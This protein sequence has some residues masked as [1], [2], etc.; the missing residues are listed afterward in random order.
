[1]KK[2]LSLT[3][4]QEHQG[5]CAIHPKH[6]Q[7]GPSFGDEVLQTRSSLLQLGQRVLIWGPE[8]NQFLEVFFFPAI[9]FFI[10]NTIISFYL[11]RGGGRERILS[12]CP[13]SVSHGILKA[14]CSKDFKFAG[15]TP[16]RENYGS[17]HL[18]MNPAAGKGCTLLVITPNRWGTF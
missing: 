5:I 8:R 12:K 11:K 7:V 15:L 1:M 17:L 13:D 3:S 9:F 14:Y 6:S 2:K 4:W 16:G 18:S 10:S